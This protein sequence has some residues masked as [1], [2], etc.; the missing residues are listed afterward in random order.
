M[1]D[2]KGATA[3]DWFHFEFVLGLGGECRYNGYE[4]CEACGWDALDEVAETP[5]EEEFDEIEEE[6][7]E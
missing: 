3:A 7:Y 1:T 2:A 4:W 6:N 5:N